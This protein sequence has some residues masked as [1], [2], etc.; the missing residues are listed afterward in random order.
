[1]SRWLLLS[2]SV[3]ILGTVTH[4]RGVRS[5]SAQSLGGACISN[6]D[7]QFDLECTNVPGAIEGQ[8]SATCNSSESCT[9]RF[10][11]SMCL[12]ADL[13]A[14]TCDANLPCPDGTACNAYGWCER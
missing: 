14:R 10:G 11:E 1:M 7:C 4:L 9:D 6:R 12:G 8:C 13:C 2:L 3:L 5:P